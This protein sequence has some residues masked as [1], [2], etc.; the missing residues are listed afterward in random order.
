M[1]ARQQRGARTNQKLAQQKQVCM[2]F[3][4]RLYSSAYGAGPTYNALLTV[5]DQPTAETGFLLLAGKVQVGLH[6][7]LDYPIRND[8]LPLLPRCNVEQ[9]LWEA[10]LLLGWWNIRS[11]DWDRLLVLLCHILGSAMSLDV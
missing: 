3:R 7:R 4:T 9:T 8:H 6:P 11:V 2:R 10:S 5:F 1:N